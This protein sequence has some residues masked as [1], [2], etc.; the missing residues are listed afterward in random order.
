MVFEN[1]KDYRRD[2]WCK[3]QTYKRKER[4]DVQGFKRIELDN[5]DDIVEDNW[6]DAIGYDQD[7]NDERGN[8]K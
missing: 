6:Q 5:D 3:K 4:K 8:G 7:S 2:K 1:E